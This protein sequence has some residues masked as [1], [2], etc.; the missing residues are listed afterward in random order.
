MYKFTSLALLV[1]LLAVIGCSGTDVKN[2]DATPGTATLSLVQDFGENQFCAEGNISLTGGATTASIPTNCDTPSHT[3][4]LLP[5]SY[6]VSLSST[7]LVCKMKA[8]TD[9]TPWAEVAAVPCSSGSSSFNLLAGARVSVSIPVTYMPSSGLITPK[10]VA[11]VGEADISL[12][13]ASSPTNYCGS[14]ANGNQAGQDECSGAHQTCLTVG[15]TSMCYTVCSVQ[16][17]CVA[18]TT[19]MPVGE[20]ADDSMAGSGNDSDGVLTILKDGTT[21]AG[22][23]HVCL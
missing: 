10:P 20:T 11:P 2:K 7:G 12:A 16:A 17:D 3:I 14:V 18:G 5:S 8:V 1:G 6:T 4:D 15:S 21:I 9:N 13:P 19:C 23:L 22:T